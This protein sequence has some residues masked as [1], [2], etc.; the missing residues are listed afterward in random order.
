MFY[1]VPRNQD[2]AIGFHVG[3]AVQAGK[4]MSLKGLNRLVRAEGHHGCG[5]GTHGVSALW[6]LI[7]PVV[8]ASAL[9]VELQ[10]IVRRS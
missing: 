8:V 3:L 2:Y 4:I 10:S 9:V 6:V 7:P 1:G 5:V